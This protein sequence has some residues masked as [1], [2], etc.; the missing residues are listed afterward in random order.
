LQTHYINQI[1]NGG[2]SKDVFNEGEGADISKVVSDLAGYSEP[3]AINNLFAVVFNVQSINAPSIQTPLGQITTASIVDMNAV[4]A[5]ASHATFINATATN[6]TV[7]NATVNLLHAVN[8]TVTNLNANVISANSIA[9][10]DQLSLSNVSANS[11]ILEDGTDN[12]P[13]LRFQNG[14]D[15]GLRLAYTGFGPTNNL[16]VTTVTEGFQSMYVSKSEMRSF[17]PLG[18]P[19]GSVT[20]PALAFD[21][22]TTGFFYVPN[23]T[24]LAITHNT[25]ER[26]HFNTSS[27]IVRLGNGSAI[28]PAHGFMTQSDM[29]MYLVN[30][31]TLG[32]STAGVNRVSVSNSEVSTSVPIRA[33]IGTTAAPGFAFNNATN[34]GFSVG[35][36]AL[37]FV[38]GGTTRASVSPNGFRIGT[39]G[40]PIP[41]IRIGLSSEI[42]SSANS[43]QI[44]ITLSPA[45]ADTNYLV[46]FSMQDAGSGD[47]FTGCVGNKNTGSFTIFWRN[48]MDGFTTGNFRI[49]WMVVKQ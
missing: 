22:L 11:V 19:A 30:S 25:I 49:Q 43:G 32:L 39:N 44:T 7:T 27:G 24:K 12:L 33:P 20:D 13:S 4:N 28:V 1:I 26:M 2:M 35:G 48:V 37:N 8:S 10:A 41:E 18:L 47:R 40:T 9:V 31:S 6:L 29:G 16:S 38:Y 14:V 46:F 3:V 21:N 15:T 17:V 34:V 45:L 23:F 5:T 36:S 42:V